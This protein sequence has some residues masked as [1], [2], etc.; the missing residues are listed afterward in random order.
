[1]IPISICNQTGRQVVTVAH[2]DGLL[3]E[4]NV[5]FVV[6]VKIPIQGNSQFL[7][8]LYVWL[9]QSYITGIRAE[10]ESKPHIKKT[11]LQKSKNT[12]K[13]KTLTIRFLPKKT[14]KIKF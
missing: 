7:Q 14:L 11:Y 2:N 13:F 5:S 12:V 4:E 3:L 9:R 10:S 1:M 6:K 8:E